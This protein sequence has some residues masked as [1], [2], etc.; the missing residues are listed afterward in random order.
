[1]KN[2]RVIVMANLNIRDVLRDMVQKSILVDCRLEL[3]DVAVLLL[4]AAGGYDR[5]QSRRSHS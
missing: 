5:K 3:D 1:M 4:S 2:I